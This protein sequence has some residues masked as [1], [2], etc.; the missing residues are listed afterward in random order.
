MEQEPKPSLVLEPTE[1]EALARRN[2]LVKD[3]LWLVKC[4]A[5]MVAARVPDTVDIDDVIGAGAIGLIKAADDFDATRGA[6]F[7]TYARHR[8]R[9]SILD[10][11]RQQDALPYSK[12]SKLRQLERAI[13][14]LERNLG[15]YPTDGE[16]AEK[17]ALSEG[18]ISD[19]LTSATSVDLYSLEALFEHGDEDRLETPE[20]QAQYPDPHSKMERKEIEALL[21]AAIR[22]LPRMERVVLSLYY[23]NELRMKEVGVV[24]DLS[25]SRV[26]QIHARAILLL[27]GR[28]RL[29]LNQ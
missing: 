9:G 21:A 7:E 10:D 23:Y 29:Y 19:L 15:R 22:E 1:T 14:E 16:I 13:E 8:I 4:I 17:A 18:E 5:R 11:L 28:L 20:L 25:E 27:R 2:Q 24:L 12:R 3:H 6:K 26:S